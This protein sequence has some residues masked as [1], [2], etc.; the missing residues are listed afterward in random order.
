MCCSPEKQDHK[1]LGFEIDGTPG[2]GSCETSTQCL[3]GLER[4]A[5]EAKVNWKGR[6]GGERRARGQGKT[7]GG[8]RGQIKGW[9]EM[10]IAPQ[11]VI[12]YLFCA[13]H[14]PLFFLPQPL[15]VIFGG[16]IAPLIQSPRDCHFSSALLGGSGA[17]DSAC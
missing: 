8:G 5:E 6:D 13:Q 4:W 11:L 17:G 9:G 15:V 3:L 1:E 12:D 16:G 10:E 2:G 14:G 7:G